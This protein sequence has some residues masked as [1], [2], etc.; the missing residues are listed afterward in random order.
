MAVYTPTYPLTLPTTTG[1]TTQNFSLTRIVSVTP[2][3]F[4]SQ[5]QVYQ[6]EGEYWRGVFKLPPM[7][8]DKAAIWL[9][10]LLQLRGKRGTFKIGDQDRKTIQGATTGTV[11]VNGA[12]QTGNSI[13]LDGL[14]ATVT[15]AFL[16]GDYIQINSYLYMVTENATS[17]GAGEADVK[18]E[19]ALRTGIEPIND[20]TTVIYT[21]T[22]TI[23][24]LES[25]LTE[26][27]TDIASKYGISFACIESLT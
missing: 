23:M 25:N 19:P 3:P 20:D 17:N 16:A 8:K 18:I 24:R 27:D 11:L 4:T 6:H 12:A 9:A 21:N 5:E 15:N 22:T 2:S 10:F 13:A 14:G 1:I 26:W 7:L